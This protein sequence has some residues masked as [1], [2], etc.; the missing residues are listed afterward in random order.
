MPRW[1]LQIFLTSRSDMAST[2]KL[3]VRRLS[4]SLLYDEFW[5]DVDERRDH[6]SLR[7]R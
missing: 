3:Y 2:T 6:V 4:T 5:M 7:K 1:N